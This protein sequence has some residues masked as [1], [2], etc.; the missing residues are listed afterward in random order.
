MSI[1]FGAFGISFLISNVAFV[2]KKETLGM[3]TGYIEC[4]LFYASCFILTLILNSLTKRMS[5]QMQEAL[6]TTDESIGSIPDVSLDYDIFQQS[7]SISVVKFGS[8]EV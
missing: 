5:K 3:V 2:E 6:D 8:S 1:A 4:V 7:N